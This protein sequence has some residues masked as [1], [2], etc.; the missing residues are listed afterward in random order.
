[1]KVPVLVRTLVITSLFAA[2]HDK[3]R[4]Q[5]AKDEPAKTAMDCSFN[6]CQ[7]QFE[8]NEL[9]IELAKVLWRKRLDLSVPEWMVSQNS[10][11]QLLAN[12]DNLGFT[13]KELIA[14]GDEGTIIEQTKNRFSVI[15][16]NEDALAFEL[17]VYIIDQ[18]F[19]SVA[20]DEKASVLAGTSESKVV[21]EWHDNALLMND[22][23]KTMGL[24]DVQ[25]PSKVDSNSDVQ[26]A[27]C[28]LR[29]NLDAKWKKS[30]SVC[31]TLRDDL[32]LIVKQAS[33]IE[34]V[35][36]SSKP[37]LSQTK[38]GKLAV[39]TGPRYLTFKVNDRVVD[40][41]DITDYQDRRS[42]DDQDIAVG[43]NSIGV[44]LGRD[45]DMA[46]IAGF[47]INGDIVCAK[48]LYLR[49]RDGDDIA[50]SYMPEYTQGNAY[51]IR[52]GTKL[53]V[54]LFRPDDFQFL[55]DP[56]TTTDSS[57]WHL[58]PPVATPANVLNG[59]CVSLQ[60]SVAKELDREQ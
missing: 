39:V 52:Y 44:R 26:T 15:G 7:K 25:L 40:T 60:S 16:P 53:G 22:R 24:E 54:A 45:R 58:S 59:R 13:M 37:T 20:V 11:I 38:I 1:M 27:L 50:L 19:K 9:G 36:T 29:K 49:L 30:A 32:R 41:V 34:Q 33:A 21:T 57:N 56:S 5:E 42:V 3:A 10:P 43:S 2:A 8:A 14:N 55:W 6:V 51:K 47:R 12:D 4:A 23:L 17:G 31:A 28:G 46:M 35:K 18:M 48:Y